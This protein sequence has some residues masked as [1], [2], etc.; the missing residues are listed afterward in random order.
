MT[1]RPYTDKYLLAWI[2]GRKYFD[3]PEVTAD[4]FDELR[5][6][7]VLLE[8][9]AL[10]R[11]AYDFETMYRGAQTGSSEQILHNGSI[12]AKL[13]DEYNYLPFYKPKKQDDK[14]G[15]FENL[16][17]ESAIIMYQEAYRRILEGYGDGK[18][19]WESDF[20]DDRFF[21]YKYY[22]LCSEILITAAKVALGQALL[23][24]KQSAD[25]LVATRI[26]KQV[27]RRLEELFSLND[28]PQFHDSWALFSYGA[29][30][31]KYILDLVCIASDEYVGLKQFVGFD[32]Y[33]NKENFKENNRPN[34]ELSKKL[35]ELKAEI[36]IARY[37]KD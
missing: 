26:S 6:L 31:W 13:S 27:L 22:R 33:L 29:Q 34:E 21:G 23:K 30:F 7:C 14:F 2:S 4:R 18:Y 36:R 32:A 24:K 1:N 5:K 20:W 17:R 19:L 28:N 11:G 8:N 37:G 35:E 25:A 3:K 12:L 10:I 16:F 15:S 9:K